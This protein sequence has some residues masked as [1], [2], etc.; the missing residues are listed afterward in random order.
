MKKNNEYLETLGAAVDLCLQTEERY[1]FEKMHDY[2]EEHLLTYH[3][4]NARRAA[5]EALAGAIIEG[6]EDDDDESDDTE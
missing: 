2:M 6:E 1:L 3:L 4:Q 5:L